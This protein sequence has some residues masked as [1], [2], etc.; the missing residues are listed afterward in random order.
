MNQ[1]ALAKELGMSRIP[2]RDAL[3]RLAAQHLVEFRDGVPVVA[4]LSIPDLEE[5]YEMREAIEPAATRIALANVGR[6]EI[7]QMEELLGFMN[8]TDELAGWLTANRR[9]HRLIY[10]QSNRTRMISLIDSLSEQTDRYL[11]H[12]FSDL[13]DHLLRFD[14]QHRMILDAAREGAG[15]REIEDLTKVHLVTAHRMILGR[16]LD[17]SVQAA[18]EPSRKQTSDT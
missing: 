17:G 11:F 1:S 14:D 2:V 16:L 5:I 15:A 8:T 3:I 18:A 10:G 4:P 7:L 13:S 9:F 6:A 12:Y